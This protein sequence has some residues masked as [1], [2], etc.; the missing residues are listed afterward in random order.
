MSEAVVSSEGK[1]E[2]CLSTL[3]ILTLFLFLTLEKVSL[4][5]VFILFRQARPNK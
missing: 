5:N 4:K 3:I 2:I 1:L